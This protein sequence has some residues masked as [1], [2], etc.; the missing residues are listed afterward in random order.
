MY[1]KQLMKRAIDII[2]YDNNIRSL[3]E[4]NSIS[5]VIVLMIS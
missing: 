2:F 5:N 1:K 4:G 3:Q